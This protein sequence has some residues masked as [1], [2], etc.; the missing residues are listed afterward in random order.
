MNKNPLLD[1]ESI[2]Q[3]IWLDYL[4]RNA[5]DN[6]ELQAADRSGWGQRPDLESFHF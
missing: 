5:L 1:L 6:G 4:R 3:S 2:G